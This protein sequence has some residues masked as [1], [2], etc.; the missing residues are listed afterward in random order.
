[1]DDPAVRAL[2]DAVRRHLWLDQGRLAVRRAASLSAAS[3]LLAGAAH[4]AVRA[5]P[6]GAVLLVIGL[7][8]VS[9]LAW[10]AWHRP[11]DASC[12]LWIDRTLGGA[13]AFTTL[14]DVTSGPQ[15]PGQAQALRWLERWLA[16]KVPEVSRSLGERS[17][18]TR[19]AAPLLSMTVCAA[20]SLF[21]LALP[22]AVPAPRA[23]GDAASNA[24][25]GAKT[26]SAA[27]AP[28]AARLASE[29]SGAL[30][31]A[32]S[33]VEPARMGAAAAS[34]T[35]PPRADEASAAAK[36]SPDA[37]A[38]A[39]RSNAGV[40]PSADSAGATA[41]AAGRSAD[42]GS[43]RDVGDSPDGRTDPGRS[44]PSTGTMPLRSEP[45]ERPAT[46][47]RG[48]DMERTAG[49]DD[50]LSG[51]GGPGRGTG[52]MV[53]AARPPPAADADRLSP[54]QAAYVRAWMKS[55]GRDR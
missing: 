22:G 47:E 21:V 3:M 15:R 16:S 5:V 30:R 1:M 23:A 9:M 49:F 12:A 34:P 44:Q 43:E 8:W 31:S 35:A 27:E 10:V 51:P 41:A 48:A 46:A 25:P 29:L 42:A 53:A 20:L 17:P 32:E 36:P 45:K 19:V 33:Q 55:T 52:A 18:S 39:G 50:S 40:A 2:L 11:S 54:T 4:L 37:A 14:L 7:A 13:S 38:P 28:V 6:A 26:G 24:V